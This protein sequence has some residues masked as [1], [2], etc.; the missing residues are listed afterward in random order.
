MAAG[1]DI[2]DTS[3]QFHFVYQA[4][5]GDADITA[6]VVSLTNTALWAKAGVMIRESLTG[7][8]R[9]GMVVV[10]AGVGYAFQRRLTAGDYSL[11]QDAGYRSAP[12]SV[13][14]VRRGYRFEAFRSSDGSSWTAIGADTIAMGATVYVGLAVTSHNADLLTTAVIDQVVVNGGAAPDPGYRR[15]RGMRGRL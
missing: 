10:T 7:E 13:R 11:H 4:V 5:T 1:A 3:D 14:L 12:G 9:H 6:R 15:I 8:S 2:W